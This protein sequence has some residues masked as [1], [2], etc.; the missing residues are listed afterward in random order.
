MKSF[1]VLRCHRR[2]QKAWLSCRLRIILGVSP[3][4]PVDKHLFDLPPLSTGLG[5][6]LK[7]ADIQ[8]QVALGDWKGQ[9]ESPRTLNPFDREM[10]KSELFYDVN[11]KAGE[12][13][14]SSSQLISEPFINSESVF[15]KKCQ[16]HWHIVHNCSKGLA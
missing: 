15:I 5:S 12:V 2:P 9:M 1:K 11:M 7:G 3:S 14:P 6:L 8:M 10:S 4:T 16:P 13:I